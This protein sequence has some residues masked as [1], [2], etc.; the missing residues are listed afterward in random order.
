M[1]LKR[2]G[3]LFF[4]GVLAAVIAL[5]VMQRLELVRDP[6]A[7]QPEIPAI[8]ETRILQEQNFQ[9]WRSY[10]GTIATDQRTILS[11]RVTSRI[12]EVPHRAGTRVKQ[13]ELLVRLDDEELL[14]EL[15]R[16]RSSQ[17]EVGSEMNLALKQLKRREG[18]Y[19][20]DVISREELDEIQARV[21]GLRAS[22]NELQAGLETVRA[23]LGYTRIKAPFTGIIGRV[24]ALPGDMAQPGKALLELEGLDE[25]KVEFV[26]PQ[27]DL[28]LV[29]AGSPV[30]IRLPGRNQEY[31][32][33]LDR[34]YPRL[35]TPGRGAPAE[36]MLS[37][38]KTRLSP[39]MQ[40]RVLVRDISLSGV[41]TVPAQAVHQVQGET[42]VY[43]L[44]NTAAR[45]QNVTTGPRDQG[46][47]VI[48][49]G[50]SPGD[51]VITTAD[52]NLAHGR[53]VRTKEGQ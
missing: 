1:R 30:R 52:P 24:H 17:E 12:L 4:L 45:R 9:R 19:K 25:L 51:A 29:Q 49:A 44:D 42:Y 53:Q 33:R 41:L 26:L 27:R 2:L 32:A 23:R 31:S 7:S 11:S 35:D 5:A 36:A 46:E 43:V 15:A 40:A 37:G 13:G 38:E 18:L 39:G 28:D 50:L 16:I 34:V 47:V 3:G 10:P 6:P 8:V 21:D 14:Q 48:L 20:Q 22:R